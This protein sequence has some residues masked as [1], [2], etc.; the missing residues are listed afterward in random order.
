MKIGLISNNTHIKDIEVAIIVNNP[1]ACI[2]YS[3]NNPRTK[4]NIKGVII[5]IIGRL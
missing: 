3:L 5:E 1:F 4:A 2:Y